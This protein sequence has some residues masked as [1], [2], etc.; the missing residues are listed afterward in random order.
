MRLR[1]AFLSCVILAWSCSNDNQP[2]KEAVGVESV[3]KVPDA[4][5]T[6]DAPNKT[7]AEGAREDVNK[8]ASAPA[9]KSEPAIEA[10]RDAGQGSVGNF[11]VKAHQ[12]NVRKGPSLEDSVIRKL[13]GGDKVAALSCEK[14]WCKIAEGEFVS[15]KYLKKIR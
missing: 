5:G 12:L 7:N 10:A 11:V 14:G 3:D 2:A 1:F 4:P 8:L 15:E 6:G 9:E 13:N